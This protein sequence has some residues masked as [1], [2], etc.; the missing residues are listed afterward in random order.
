M[1]QQPSTT[2]A[3]ISIH[4]SALVFWYQNA[5]FTIT[6]ASFFYATAFN[7]FNALILSI[8]IFSI[9]W[10]LTRPTGLKRLLNLLSKQRL[11]L[12]AINASKF[13]RYVMRALPTTKYASKSTLFSIKFSMLF[14]IEL[15]LKNAVGG[16]LFLPPRR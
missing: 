11:I 9:L 2:V 8:L 15:H 12:R 3:G 10:L 14:N 16:P 6:L 13:K 4:S 5:L 1:T 7:A